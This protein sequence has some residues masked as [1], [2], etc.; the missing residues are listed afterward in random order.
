MAKDVHTVL[1]WL[2]SRL[3]LF[4]CVQNRNL[5]GMITNDWASEVEFACNEM[6]NT[7]LNVDNAPPEIEGCPLTKPTNSTRMMP[8]K[9]KFDA[10]KR[11]DTT[12]N[13]S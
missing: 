13:T 4:S 9:G 1:Y 5:G 6:I 3:D 7:L 8:G 2:Q 11:Y 10:W 12:F